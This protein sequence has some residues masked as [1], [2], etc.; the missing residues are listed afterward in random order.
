MSPES[1]PPQLEFAFRIIAEVDPELPIER[2]AD[3][4]LTIIPITGG[5]VR[6]RINGEVVP[7]GADWCL[8]R[9]DDAFEVEARYW[10][11]TDAGDIVDVVN[12]GRIAPADDRHS[13]GIFMTTPQF[14]TTAPAL[15]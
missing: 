13:S 4:T 12:L 1:S 7:G 8:F 6:G 14:R 10:F 15:Q 11:R 5:T 9:N 2:R 3:E